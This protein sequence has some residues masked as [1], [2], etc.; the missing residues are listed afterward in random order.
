METM[1]CQQK[2]IFKAGIILVSGKCTVS[3]DLDLFPRF[4]SSDSVTQI[5]H[6]GFSWDLV[7]CVCL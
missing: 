2:Q 7:W 6:T 3:S 5:L 4:S 1:T